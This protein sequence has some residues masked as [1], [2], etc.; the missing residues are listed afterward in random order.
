MTSVSTTKSSTDVAHLPPVSPIVRWSKATT[1]LRPLV[2]AAPFVLL[3]VAGVAAYHVLELRAA[4]KVAVAPAERAPVAADEFVVTGAQSRSLTIAPVRLLQFQPVR[5][6]EGKIALDENKST[7]VFSQYSTAR[8]IRTFADS[9][10]Y[11]ARGAPLMR[12]E[13]PDMV[14]AANDLTTAAAGVDKAKSQVRLLA[15]AE[16]REHELYEAKGAALKDWQQAQA[17]L[18]GA[19]SDQRSA[20]I[21]LAAVRNRLVI[22]GKRPTDV[23]QL[24]SRQAIDAST[25]ITAP[26][27]GVVVQRKVGPGQYITAAATDPVFV[28]GDLSTVWLVA[29]VRE[30]DVPYVK[31]GQHVSVTVLAF[32]GRTFDATIIG[33]GSTIDPTTRRLPVRAEMANPDGLLKPEMFAEFSIA[34]GPAVESPAVPDAALIHEAD[35]VRVWVQRGENRFAVRTIKTGVHDQRMVQ[36][37]S[38]LQPG[39]R[40]VD[41]G[42]LFIDRAAH[43]E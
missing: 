30:A 21:A 12:I 23:A 10:D 9:G 15:A 2:W 26:I 4:R 31:L 13:T 3:A 1:W 8:V 22:L 35:A 40:I 32:P 17:D 6:A 7:P 11:V 29:S 28:L 42:A 24:E 34:V 18:A 43:P 19:R 16:T 33:V 27:S 37:L 20:E 5:Q 14:Q 25:D 41:A 36:V 38:G 39:E